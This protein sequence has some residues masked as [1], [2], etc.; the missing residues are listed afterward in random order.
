MVAAEC[1]YGAELYDPEGGPIGICAAYL[2]KGAIGFLG[3]T[4]IA[5]G[6]ADSNGSA[7]LLC[8]FF[9]ESV[10]EGASL[11]RALL[12]ARQRF[13]KEAAR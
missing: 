9:L 12:E 1:C 7:D 3:S 5:Y 4:T 8:R 11:G 6:P 2:A 10:L 13:A